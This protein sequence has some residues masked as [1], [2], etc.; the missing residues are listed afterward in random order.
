M[1]DTFYEKESQL[2][3]LEEMNERNFSS[4]NCGRIIDDQ[5]NEYRNEDGECVFLTDYIKI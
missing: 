5:G 2:M 3:T 4:D 1:K